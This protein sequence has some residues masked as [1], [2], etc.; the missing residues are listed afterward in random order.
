MIK[1]LKETLINRQQEYLDYL[2]DLVAI[3][4]QHIGQG[5]EGGREK[6]GQEYIIQLMEKMKADEIKR[7]QMSESY[8]QAAI[9]TFNEGNPDHNYQDRFNVYATFKGNNQQKTIL[10]NGHMDTMPPG[11]LELWDTNPLEPTIVDNKMIGLGAAD[12]KSGLMASI[13]AVKLLQDA[14][15]ELPVNVKIASV[16]DE[17]GGGNGS[18]Q[19]AQVIPPVDYTVV[20]EPTHYELILAHMGFI[21]F[22][23][24]VTG[25]AHHSGSKWKGVSAIEK[26]Q[27][28]MERLN[29]LEYG[30]LFDYKHPLLPPPN[31]NFGVLEGGSS[32]A[33]VAGYCKTEMCIHYHSDRMDFHS[34]KNEVESA[35]AD[36]VQSDEWLKANPPIVTIFQSGGGFE[37]DEHSDVVDYFKTAF[38]QSMNHEVKV[39]GSPAGCDSRIWKNINGAATI[40]YGPGTLEACHSPNEFVDIQEYWDSILIYA[41]LILQLGKEGN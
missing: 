19:A 24:E 11:P 28:I 29:R 1:Q 31:L 5:I 36:V 14:E 27:L 32:G 20:C 37:M 7:D 9:E 15:I 4:T 23:I 25:K 18:I 34:V 30:W 40:Q 22:R 10:F 21:F 38:Q 13:L 6:L 41:N 17:E 12:M 3:D 33:T 35:I 8:I 26:I 16:C 39:A 2:K